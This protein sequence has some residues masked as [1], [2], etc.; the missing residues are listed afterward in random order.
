MS[1]GVALQAA[2]GITLLNFVRASSMLRMKYS[3]GNI[4][5]HLHGEVFI[6]TFGIISKNI[7]QLISDQLVS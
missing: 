3:L 7:K 1:S 6:T 4:F 2:F 5:N